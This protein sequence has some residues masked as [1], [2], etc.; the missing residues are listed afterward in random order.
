MCGSLIV[1]GFCKG[2]AL[3]LLGVMEK[4]VRLR[5]VVTSGCET[6]KAFGLVSSYLSIS[7]NFATCYLSV[8]ELWTQIQNVS[9]SSNWFVRFVGYLMK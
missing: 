6:V 1:A 5:V 7:F 2:G 9:D 3:V 8:T 4:F